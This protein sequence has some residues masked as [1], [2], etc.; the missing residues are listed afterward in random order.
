[1]DDTERQAPCHRQ[2]RYLI[3]IFYLT[4]LIISQVVSAPAQQSQPITG[5]GSV[6]HSVIVELENALYKLKQLSTNLET[7]TSKDAAMLGDAEPEFDLSDLE[8]LAGAHA[9]SK[10]GHTAENQSGSI[11]D[12]PSGPGDLPLEEALQYLLTLAK[13]RK[14]QR[15]DH[16]IPFPVANKEEQGE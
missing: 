8:R 11:V 10:S 3:A 6:L 4:T 15:R 5:S 14:V 2:A 7:L 9:R 16:D 13:E 12:R 1:M